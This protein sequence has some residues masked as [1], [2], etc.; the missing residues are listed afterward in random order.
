MCIY[1]S[2]EIVF[3]ISSKGKKIIEKIDKAGDF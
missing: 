3:N 1:Y 2:H